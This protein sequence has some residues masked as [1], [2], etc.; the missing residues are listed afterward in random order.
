MIINRKCEYSINLEST[1]DAGKSVRILLTSLTKPFSI[2]EQFKATALCLCR[3]L[4]VGLSSSVWSLL[5]FNTH[6]TMWENIT[7]PPTKQCQ[8]HIFFYVMFFSPLSVKYQ[9]VYTTNRLDLKAVYCLHVLALLDVSVQTQ[10]WQS[11]SLFAHLRY[12]LHQPFH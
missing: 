3:R 10:H 11:V 2:N 9:G 4:F 12:S 5:P 8:E 7:Q 6:C 1:P